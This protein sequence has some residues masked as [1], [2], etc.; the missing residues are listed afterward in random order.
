MLTIVQNTQAFWT[1][2]LGFMINKERF[3]KIELVGILACF[4]GVVMMAASGLEAENKQFQEDEDSILTELHL[5]HFKR[6]IGILVMCF[7]AFNDGMLAVLARTM[8]DV[9][10]SLL[11]FWFSAIGF[12]LLNI[13]LA[14]HSFVFQQ[15]PQIFRYS[16]S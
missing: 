12:F 11:M 6:I 14:F 15:I 8:K 4:V 1:V 16:L 2:L 9:H 10:F 5:H 7:V 3:L 13:F